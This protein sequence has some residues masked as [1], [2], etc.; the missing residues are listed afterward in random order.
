MYVDKVMSAIV[1]KIANIKY[2]KIM[3]PFDPWGPAI[4]VCQK[5]AMI[6]SGMNKIIPKIDLFI[7][8]NRFFI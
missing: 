6:I 3:K 1:P 2:G 8:P 4:P 5:K 7:T